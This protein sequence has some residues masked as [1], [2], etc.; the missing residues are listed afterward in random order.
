MEPFA[1]FQL[2]Q[3]LFN[4]QSPA[5]PTKTEDTTP[6]SPPPTKPIPPELKTDETTALSPSQETVLR[7]LS[8]HDNRAKRTKKP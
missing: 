1:L 2:L 6:D 3:S 8:Q 7:F 4:A 5:E